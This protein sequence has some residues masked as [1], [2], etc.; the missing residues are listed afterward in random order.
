MIIIFLWLFKWDNKV[1]M[2]AHLFTTWFTE[3]FKPTA[4]TYCSEKKVHSK[5]L[6]FIDNVPGHPGDLSETYNKSPVIFMQHMDQGVILI[7][8]SHSLENIFCKAIAAIDS[9]LS[10]GSG[11]K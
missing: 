3:H 8:K 11:G 4:E 1:S 10:D 9:D 7:F 6:L 5:I 2:T